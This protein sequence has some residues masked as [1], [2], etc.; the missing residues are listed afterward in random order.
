MSAVSAILAAFAQHFKSQ[1][2]PLV[3]SG[4]YGEAR[5]GKECLGYAVF[6]VIGANMTVDIQEAKEPPSL[7]N[8]ALGEFPS[9]F[10]APL[11]VGK[12]GE[13]ATQGFDLRHSIQ[14][15][16]MAQTVRGILLQGFRAGDA[17]QCQQ[18]IGH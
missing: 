18:H 2:D 6:A 15:D 5:S 8:P 14:T 9:E 12:P 1:K 3:R 10:P 13:L 16:N 17:Q 4:R 11:H 7:P